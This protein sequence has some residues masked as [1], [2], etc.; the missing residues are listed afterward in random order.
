MS[1]IKYERVK[2]S[3]KKLIENGKYSIGDKLPTE[4][5]LMK[6]FSVSRYTIRRAVGEL[7]NE[8]YIYRIQG[9]GMYVDDWKKQHKIVGN[10]K[11]IG[12][13]TTHL[14]DYI[15][16]RII[17][18]IDRQ[19]SENGYSLI[20]SNTHNDRQ[21]E[22]KAIHRMIDN[23]VAGIIIEPSQSALPLKDKEIYQ[24]IK[25]A[26][27]PT[28]FIN[29]HYSEL[30]F[31]YLE[32]NDAQAEQ[33][34]THHLIELGHQKILGM[35]QV[36]DRQGANR[37]RGFLDA[38]LEYPQISYMSQ[39]IMYQSTQDMNPVVK[40]AVTMLEGKDKPTALVCYNDELA[41]QMM[42]VIRSIDLRIPEDISIVGFDDF[43]MGHYVTPRLTTIE[44]PKEKMGVDAANMIMSMINGEK[45]E[46]K[47][48]ELRLIYNDSIMK[49]KNTVNF[50]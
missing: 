17:S 26:N 49:R 12:V 4:S 47:S 5:E 31:P 29:A 40:R 18:G 42:D 33:E 15:F 6:R 44:H 1:E 9:G 24:K 20:L 14:A 21:R 43:I 13:I 2:S 34:M 7:E 39:T 16:P 35:F 38:Y 25:E 10:T 30:D 45:V 27:I 22:K 23:Q 3:L 32:V 11:M 36:D 28:L 41:I 46:S 19:I 37:L 50:S 8:H 48:Y